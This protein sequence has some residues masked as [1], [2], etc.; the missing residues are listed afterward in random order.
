MQLAKRIL[1]F[2]VAPVV[3]LTMITAAYLTQG[4]TPDGV[5]AYL[6]TLGGAIVGMPIGWK[7]AKTFLPKFSYE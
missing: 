6:A 5:T 2:G 3:G 4:A 1:L 7:L